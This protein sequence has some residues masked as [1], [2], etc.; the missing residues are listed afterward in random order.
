M[1]SERLTK[2]QKREQARELARLEREKR[3]K[4]EARNKILIRVGATVGV[5]AVLGAIGWGIWAGTRPAGPG[6]ANM[7][8]DGILLT[9][10]DGQITAERN[11]GIP[12]GGEPVATAPDDY[13]APA[14]IVTY[15]DYGCPFC[16]QFENANG[17][18]IEEL[19]ASGLATLEV[20]PVSI[21]DNGFQ[22]SRYPS[23][24]A[25][26]AACVAA[27]EPDSFLDVNAALF[28]AQPAEQTPGL[29]NAE[30]LDVLSTAGVSSPDVQSCVTAESYRGWVSA[31][32]QRVLADADLANPTS[33]GFGTPTVLVNGVRYAPSDLGSAEEFAAF[34]AANSDLPDAPTAP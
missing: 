4:A 31:A 13:D 7:L 33:G 25:N 24:A 3:L 19:V 21:L 15:I 27:Y 28:A 10:S 17:T 20:H 34:V 26:A 8:S 9:G 1:P 23:R 30:I 22:G 32:T 12:E 14:H 18:Q 11:D 2:D 16:G 29:T 6:P 5:V